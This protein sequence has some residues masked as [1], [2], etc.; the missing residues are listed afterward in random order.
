MDEDNEDK[1]YT[2][3]MS[4][5]GKAQDMKAAKK[6]GEHLDDLVDKEM[7]SLLKV[8]KGLHKPKIESI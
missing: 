5:Q 8:C 1:I 4:E 2:Q 3:I 7:I 6:K